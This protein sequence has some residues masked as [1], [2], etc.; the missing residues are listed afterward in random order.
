[1][2]VLEAATAAA[3]MGWMNKDKF[4]KIFKETYSKAFPDFDLEQVFWRIVYAEG[5]Y[6][7]MNAIY[8]V[9]DVWNDF[10]ANFAAILSGKP[11][12]VI[13]YYVDI[14]DDVLD[15]VIVYCEAKTSNV[16]DRGDCILARITELGYEIED[17]DPVKH[18]D[19]K[20]NLGADVLENLLKKFFVDYMPYVVMGI[21]ALFLLLELKN[22]KTR[23][24]AKGLLK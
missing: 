4:Q 3:Q 21:P 2:V 6:L 13:D 22:W 24:R 20:L 10:G 7:G 9:S 5:I 19:K 23:K 14:P 11:R 17:Y 16:N 12:E 15:E 1:M 18:G 8:R